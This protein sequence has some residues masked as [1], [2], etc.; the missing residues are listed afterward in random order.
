[1]PPHARITAIQFRGESLQITISGHPVDAFAR[2]ESVRAVLGCTLADEITL[3]DTVPLG[4]QLL[5][6]ATWPRRLRPHNIATA[7]DQ[8][9]D[10]SFVLAIDVRDSDE[11]WYLMTESFDFRKSLG[12]EAAHTKEP[13]VRTL[14]ERLTRFAP[15]ATR[16]AFVDALIERSA[17]PPPLE[18]LNEFF[19]YVM[20]RRA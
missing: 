14:L 18:S 3:P 9:E 8:I 19:R 6:A 4:I 5:N 20:N 12:A 11:L 2:P 13:N 1:M 17:L 15:G 7:P 10:L 16:D